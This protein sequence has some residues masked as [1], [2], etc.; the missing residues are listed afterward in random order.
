MDEHNKTCLKQ[1]Q[2]LN[3]ISKQYKLT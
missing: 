2:A 3:V 1:I